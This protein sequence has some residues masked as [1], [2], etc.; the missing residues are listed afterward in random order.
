MFVSIP[1]VAYNR[2][3]DSMV[4]FHGDDFLAEGEDGALDKL[5]LVLKAFEVKC[6]PRVGPGGANK[7]KLLHRWLL[8]TPR[9]YAYRPDDKHVAS[10]L[11]AFWVWKMLAEPPRPTR[12]RQ[13]RMSLTSS[14]P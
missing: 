12:R 9:G 11:E 1:C 8:W 13:A 3:E 10:L 14:S 2:K 6:L 4:I 5:D 7:V